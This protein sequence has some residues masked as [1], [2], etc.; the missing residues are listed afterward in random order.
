MAGQECRTTASGRLP[1][2]AVER[3]PDDRHGCD[4]LDRFLF[5]KP[6]LQSTAG[7]KYSV[8]CPQTLHLNIFPAREPSSIR[9]VCSTR[10][11]SSPDPPAVDC[12]H[13][14]LPHLGKRR[15]RCTLL[16][17]KFIRS[18]RCCA[19]EG[20][21]RSGAIVEPCGSRRAQ[22]VLRSGRLAFSHRRS[23]HG[24]MSVRQLSGVGIAGGGPLAPQRVHPCVGRRFGLL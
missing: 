7:R 6:G 15:L 11:A 9:C 3:Q 5:N 24:D 10:E 18:P 17:W 1:L 19:Q 23:W 22:N 2:S 16:P 14:G 21:M 20:D 8:V 13:I 12:P 4:G